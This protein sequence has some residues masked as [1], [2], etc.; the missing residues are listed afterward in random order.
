MAD[1]AVTCTEDGSYTAEYIGIVILCSVLVIAWPIGMPVLLFSNLFAV[2]AK[3]KA[4]DED[5]LK[6]FGSVVGDYTVAC[7]YW[8]LVEL[9]RKLTLTGLIGLLGRGSVCQT[10]GAVF[11]AVTFL[12]A[13]SWA[14]PF[15][16]SNLNVVKLISEFVILAVLIV[17][18]IQQ[19]YIASD[20]FN[21]EEAITIDGYGYVQTGLCL[22]LMPTTGFFVVKQLRDI[23]VELVDSE[24]TN[25]LDNSQRMMNPLND[26]SLDY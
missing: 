22:V 16:S 15:A 3:L 10:L 5:T 13:H 11:V 21:A 9:V 23:R 6:L 14:Q 8:E 12:T 18:I 17:C 4:Q 24:G 19:T 20:D 2:R 25:P 7:W 1:H 26:N